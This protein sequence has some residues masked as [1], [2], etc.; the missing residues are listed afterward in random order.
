MNEKTTPLSMGTEPIKKLI[1][2]L[3]IP[4]M[5]GMIF[6]ALDNIGDALF[7]SPLGVNQLSAIL[8]CAPIGQAVVALGLLF[9]NGSGAYIPRLLGAKKTD[10]A[11]KVASTALFGSLLLGIITVIFIFLNLEGILRALGAN[12]EN[13][14]FAVTYARVYVPSLLLNLFIVT[15]NSLSSSEGR[16]KLVMMVNVLTALLNFVLNPICIY[17]LKMGIAGAAYAT[18]IAQGLS[19]LLLLSNILLKKSVFHFRISN[20]RLN[21][22]ILA[23]IFQ[24]GCSTLLFQLFT[25]I[26]TW[27]TNKQAA[28][29]GTPTIAA[30]GTTMRIFSIGT[31]LVFGFSKGFQAIAGFNFGAKKI[32][33]V[34]ESIDFSIKVTTG[35][36]LL[37]SILCAVFAQNIIGIFSDHNQ[38]VISTGVQAIFMQSF[39]FVFFGIYTVY[40]SLLLALGKVKEGFFLG[41][42]RQGIC[43]IPLLAILPAILGK[44]GILMS[45]PISDILSFLISLIFV[46]I[47][48][49]FLK[50]TEAS[51]NLPQTESPAAP[52]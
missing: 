28:F 18:V 15:M 36:C 1:L 20:I 25:S 30:L 35:F 3:G 37:L 6:T 12:E 9:G 4:I 19:S 27:F 44:T 45:Q 51:A 5:I 17:V 14:P 10:I 41:L 32:D 29:F 16:G 24:V 13:V 21:K 48:S 39:S 42:C 11:N 46:R 23:P 26:A 40:S 22:E 7:V 43:F 31:M 50:E 2:Q 38:E 33:R 8:I 52:L 49:R 47:T 34:R